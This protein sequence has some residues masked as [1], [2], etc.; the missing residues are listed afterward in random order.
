LNTTQIQL[1]QFW[2]QEHDIA[3]L[4]GQL[5]AQLTQSLYKRLEAALAECV[6]PEEKET[7]LYEVA[8]AQV[9]R[10]HYYPMARLLLRAIYPD[11]DDQKRYN[12]WYA[13]QNGDLLSR[14]G[15]RYP[16][17]HAAFLK[18]VCGELEYMAINRHCLKRGS[19]LKYEDD[20]VEVSVS[21]SCATN[22]WVISATDQMEE[23]P[24]KTAYAET[25]GEALLIA[26]G[27]L[28]EPRSALSVS[29]KIAHPP[30]S[31]SFDVIPV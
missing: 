16:V 28:Q 14:H 31:G 21:W 7:L 30:T 6:R 15:A 25:L 22:E 19:S 12:L 8:A 26:V 9:E 24:Y 18:R 4:R 2:Q 23:Y 10:E 29:P 11:A 27:C 17:E 20:C 3:R 13:K 1:R 5:A